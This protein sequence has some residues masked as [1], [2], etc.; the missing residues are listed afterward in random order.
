VEWR[1]RVRRSGGVPLDGLAD[2]AEVAVGEDE[3]DVAADEGQQLLH[4]VAG[5]L[6]EEDVDHL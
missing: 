4:G 1:E 5:V 6:L 2:L 3:A